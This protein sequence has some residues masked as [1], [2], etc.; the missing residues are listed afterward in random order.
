MIVLK[1]IM[2]NWIKFFFIGFLIGNLFLFINGF[3][4]YITLDLKY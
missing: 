4:F 3:M 2:Y 1:S